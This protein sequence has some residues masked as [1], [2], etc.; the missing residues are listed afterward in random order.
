MQ[1]AIRRR[2]F[3]LVE[4]LVVIAIIAVLI[5]ILLPSLMKAREAAN[6]AACSS[7]LRQLAL[8]T[9]MYLQDN[10]YTFPRQGHANEALQGGV[11]CSYTVDNYS[12]NDMYALIMNYLGAPLSIPSTPGSQGYTV[13][14]LQPSSLTVPALRCPSNT[15]FQP[16]TAS[17][18]DDAIWYQFYPGSTNDVAVRPWKLVALANQYGTCD[19]NV[20]LWGDACLYAIPSVNGLSMGGGTNH[21]NTQT[22]SPAGGNVACLDGSVQ[23]F[24]YSKKIPA[25]TPS[26]N[27]VPF[28]VMPGNDHTA[29][30]NN[31]VF[32]ISDASGNFPIPNDNAYYATQGYAPLLVGDYEVPLGM[33]GRNQYPSNPLK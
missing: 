4:L 21:W 17:G 3:T 1:K 6:R 10:K 5:S 20:A 16:C 7:N 2:A 33:V 28:S 18:A 27:F 15:Q 13:P 30:P 19:P 32:M 14:D 29:Y 25:G 26:N 22:N 31:A 9:L 11:A 23:W 8:A 12:G 24:P